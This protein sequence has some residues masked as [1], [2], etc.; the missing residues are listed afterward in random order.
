[1]RVPLKI[2]RY[3]SV[4]EASANVRLVKMDAQGY[5]CNIV[6]G[7]GNRTIE[8]LKTEIAE[9][10]LDN[11]GGCSKIKLVD[12]LKQSGLHKTREDGPDAIFVKDDSV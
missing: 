6:R 3:D 2:K 9:K 11:I 5:E 4:I 7:F 1:M 10:W 8:K 12:L